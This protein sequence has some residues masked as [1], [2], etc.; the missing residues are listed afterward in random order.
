M[1]AHYKL[2]FES[3]AELI[4][5]WAIEGAIVLFAILHDSTNFQLMSLLGWSLFHI[6]LAICRSSIRN[7]D[8]QLILFFGI[9]YLELVFVPIM[10][11]FGKASFHPLP[12]MPSQNFLLA[13]QLLQFLAYVVS[14]AGLLLFERSNKKR[15][16][17]TVYKDSGTWM[18]LSRGIG[19]VSILVIFSKP[20]FVIDYYSGNGASAT[21]LLSAYNSLER[22][23]ILV[24]SI[25]WVIYCFQRIDALL[26]QSKAKYKYLFCLIYT[27][28]AIFPISL[29]RMSRAALFIPLISFLI[30]RSPRT[31]KGKSYLVGISTVLMFSV[32]IISLG[33]YRANV[34][35]TEGGQYSLSQVGA[36]NTTSNLDTLQNYL[37]AYPF[38]AFG[39]EN[40]SRDRISV[41]TPIYSLLSPLPVLH[42]RFQ[43]IDGTAIYNN[44]IYG[45]RASDQILSI[46]L[47]AY[48]SWGLI[49]LIVLSFFA[50]YISRKLYRISTQQGSFTIRYI[51]IFSYVW[52]T[53]FPLFSFLVYSQIFFFN[54]LFIL[55]FFSLAPKVLVTKGIGEI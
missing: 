52:L 15:R 48:L 36:S 21:Q 29:L 2:G 19:A 16:L 17:I 23:F 20:N 40:I 49:G 31:L 6:V 33:A 35:R 47:E 9:W 18:K 10:S 54:V 25:F 7:L 46:I 26:D 1:Y 39:L 55:I 43:S 14:A 44:S 28:L 22:F 42:S 34:L 38:V 11:L 37:N 53:C 12:H 4:V 13:A 50:G 27:I 51:T 5:S 45:F 32:L 24:C 8:L 30:L 41:A 3:T